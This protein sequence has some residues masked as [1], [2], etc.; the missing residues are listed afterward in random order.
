M[1]LPALLTTAEFSTRTGNKIAADDPRIPGLIDGATKGVRRYCRWHVAPV[2][3]ETRTFD[4]PGG[5]LL[6]LPSLHVVSVSRVVENGVALLE[7]V[8]FDWS[9][10]GEILRLCRPWTHR[11]RAIEVE[12][13][14]G[15]ESAADL[16]QVIQQ[17]VANAAA[18]PLGATREQAGQ[19]SISWGSTAPNVSGGM[20]LLQRD[21]AILDLYKLP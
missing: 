1:N 4:G 18:S 14:H 11:W 16:V 9:E 17:V 13:K 20:S 8:D 5:N 10:N 15:F 3:T 12:F 7:G 2:I 19:V 21:L 6:V